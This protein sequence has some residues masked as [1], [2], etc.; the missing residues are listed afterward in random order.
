MEEARLLWNDASIGLP[1]FGDLK[2]LI[3]GKYE[4]IQGNWKNHLRNT[5]TV[6]RATGMT[7]TRQLYGLGE[8]GPNL[9]F[10][11]HDNNVTNL[12]TAAL[13]RIL[14]VK[15]DNGEFV[16]PPQPVAGIFT[17]RMGH[18][19]RSLIAIFEKMVPAERFTPLTP[20]EFVE[21]Y[22]GR[23]Q[24]IY[25]AARVSLL[26]QEIKERDAVICPFVKAEKAEMKKGKRAVPRMI[27]PRHPRYS[28]SLGCFI[29]PVEK[30]IYRAIAKLFG[31]PTVMKGLNPEQQGMA[32]REAWDS[33][34]HPVAVGLD[35]SRFDQHVSVD[36]LKFEHS[37]YLWLYKYN[38]ALADLLKWQLC[39]KMRC[40]IGNYKVQYQVA[41]ARMSGDMNTGL[42]NCMLMC[43]M[44]YQYL[45]DIGVRGRLLNNGDDCVLIIEREE[46]IKLEGLGGYFLDLGF[47]MVREEPV[48]QF[49]RV[50]FCQTV[51][52]YDGRGWIF[53]R[54]PRR[55]MAKDLTT[56]THIATESEYNA[57]RRAVGECGIALAGGIPVL[58]AFYRMLMR[59]TGVKDK[60]GYV[61]VEWAF[62]DVMKGMSPRATFD[63]SGE[64]RES[65]YL[66]TGYTPSEQVHIEEYFNGCELKY[67]DPVWRPEFLHELEGC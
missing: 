53:V 50:E 60:K 17:G 59:G 28:L 57:Y 4:G 25:E 44:I 62:A 51:P 39:N 54:N 61:I 31:G 3:R 21:G 2:A 30:F 16:P 65:Y 43:L 7:R 32:A 45:S 29:R 52:I 27:H 15:G 8:Y 47:N 14:L 5:M 1:E 24:R 49:E 48:E 64:A 42:G 58:D 67:G 55:A 34:E 66:A 10:N 33:F 18:A 13:E 20:S 37:L 38:P 41:G 35:A 19:K 63:I 9:D 40:F 12:L 22:R 11:V 26:H 36:A 23:R 56:V 46:L 6:K